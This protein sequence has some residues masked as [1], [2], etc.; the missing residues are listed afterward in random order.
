MRFN[1]EVLIFLYILRTR[2]H[3]DTSIGLSEISLNWQIDKGKAHLE[4]TM[5][6]QRVLFLNLSVRWGGWSIPAFT[7]KN[8]LHLPVEYTGQSNS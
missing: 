5:K 2:Y 7:N 8:A 4:Q 6:V 3:D 1:S